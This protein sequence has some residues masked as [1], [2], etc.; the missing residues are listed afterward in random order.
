VFPQ[1]SSWSGQNIFENL[2]DSEKVL[3]CRLHGSE[4]QAQN[5]RN[6]TQHNS[7]TQTDIFHLESLEDKKDPSTPGSSGGSFCEHKPFPRGPLQVVDPHRSCHSTSEHSLSSFS[8]DPYGERGYGLVNL[9]SR[10]MLPPFDTVIG[11]CVLVGS[12]LEEAGSGMKHSGGTW[13]KVM[14]N[15]SS[16]E[17]EK[18]SVYKKPKQRKSIFDP[19]TF[20]RPQTPPKVDYLS[21]GPAPAHSPQSSKAEGS[22]TPPTPPKRSDSIKFKH[23]PQDSSGSETTLVPSSPSTSPPASHP[24]APA[25]LG[26]KQ[27][28]PPHK[29]RGRIP[30]HYYREEEGDCA[31]LPGRK[32]CEEDDNFQRGDDSDLKRPRPK[33]API[34]R[35]KLTPVAIPNQSL[36]VKTGNG[37]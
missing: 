22:P 29:S 31:L 4:V 5:K 17:T 35:H 18:F 25:P 13:P 30:G 32:P 24:S 10:R 6:L 9:G 12:T 23:R 28:S 1:S 37:W 8:S 27:D 7:S 11:D 20:K 14:V 2:K 21:P 34:L 19:D 15:A 33:S 36:Q 16:A 3:N 26:L